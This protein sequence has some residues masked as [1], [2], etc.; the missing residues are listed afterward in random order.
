MPFTVS[1]GELNST[2]QTLSFDVTA[3]ADTA[4]ISG[5]ATGSVTEDSA[6]QVSGT[7]TVSDP[8]AGEAFFQSEDNIAGTYG[9]LTIDQH[10]EWSYTASND[11]SA[12]QSLADGESLT[13]IIEVQ[14]IDGT[15]QNIV[16]TINGTNDQT[17][18]EEAAYSYTIP[19][20]AFVDPDSDSLSVSATLANGDSLPAWLN[21][22][23]ASR[24]FSGTPDDA[25][26]GSL[27]VK[28]M[29]SD[30]SGETELFFG[31][32]IE[33][34]DDAPVANS[35]DLGDTNEDASIIITEASLLANASDVDGDSLSVTNLSLSADN[36][37]W[38]IDGGNP[39]NSDELGSIVNNN[40]GTWTFT[41]IANLNSGGMNHVVFDVTISDG[42]VG[43]E[44]TTTAQLGITPVNDG[45]VAVIDSADATADTGTS[46]TDNILFNDSDIE[47]DSLT[48]E[49]VNGQL[50]S[51]DTVIE[52]RF[53]DLTISADGSYTY[54]PEA[55]DLD[56]N[57]VGQWT[58]DEGNGLIAND[59]APNDVK[60]SNGTLES[61]ATFVDGGV[62]GGA[63]QLD[64]DLARVAIANSSE[65]NTYTGTKSQYTISMEF[66]ISPDNDLSGRQVLYEQGGASHGFN[67]YIDD[68]KLYAGAWTSGNSN[69]LDVDIGDIDSSQWHQV[70]FVLDADNSTME[71]WFNGESIGSDTGFPISSHAGAVAFGGI[72]QHTQFH[73][74][75]ANVDQGYGFNGLIDEARIYNRAL[76]HQEVNALKY[77]F[78]TG[79]L[80]DTFEYTVSDGTDT[81]TSSL[82][83]DVNRTPE[84]LSGTLSATED[85]GEIVGQLSA[86]D[87]DANE[88]LT[89]S[90]ENQ[91]SEGS[92][93]INSDGSYSF[94]PGSD[95]QNLA[96]DATR[97]VTFEYRVTDAQGD[98]SSATVTVTV[99]G[100]NDNPTA[101]DSTLTLSE[102][103][104]HTFAVADFGFADIDVG[105]NLHSVTIKQL[106]TNGSLQ[107]NGVDVTADQVINEVD[108]SNLTF[109]PAANA[110]GTGYANLIF[111]V[112][113]GELSSAEQTL[114]FDVAP[115]N[116]E[117]VVSLSDEL[118]TQIFDEDTSL[119]LQDADILTNISDIDTNDVLSISN[120]RVV[121]GSAV[122]VDNSDGTWTVT[123]SA[124]WVGS[125]RLL[126]DVSDGHATVT[127]QITYSVTNVGDP[128]IIGGEDTQIFG[129]DDY[130]FIDHKQLSITDA[131]GNEASFNAETINGTYGAL[132]I[133]TTGQWLYSLSRESADLQSM[134]NGDTLTDTVVVQ[135]VDGTTHDIVITIEGRNDQ[136]TV[137]TVDL[138]QINEDN[139]ITIT[140]EQLLA[141]ASDI[142]GDNL[143]VTNVELSDIGY[144]DLGGVVLRGDY[145]VD[146]Q[147]MVSAGSVGTIVDNGNGAWTFTPAAN[148]NGDNVNFNFTVSDGHN[149]EA[150][151]SATL[152]VTAVN[153][154]PVAVADTGSAT[155]GGDT[156][157]GANVILNDTD[158]ETFSFGLTVEDVNG[159]AVSGDTVIEGNFGDLTISE[160][161]QWTYDPA[162][163]DVTSNKIAHWRFDETSGSTAVDSAPDDS[164]TNNGTLTNGAAFVGG[165]VDGNAVAFGSSG[166]KVTLA[167]SAEINT[168]SGSK[169][170]YTINLEFQTDPANDLNGRQIL[171]EQGGDGNGY[172]VY[173]DDGVLYA[174][175][176]SSDNNWFG[177]W[178]STDLSSIDTTQWH[179]VS[180][181]LDA[182]NNRLEAWLDGVSM[183]SDTA[184]PM[185][186]HGNDAAFGGLNGTTLF[187][188]GASSSSANYD[189]SGRIDEASLFDRALTHQEINALKYEFETGTLQDTFEYTVSDGTDTS[190]S[191]L[192]IDVNRTPEALSGTLS[193]TEDGGE[194]V[195]QLSAIDLDANEVLTF[196][197]ENQPSE[198][199]VTINSD[200]S[201]SFSPGSDFQNLAKDATRDVTFEYRVTDAQGDSSSAT[202]TV[203]VTGTNDN[204]TAA[205]ST[206]TLSEDGFHTFAVADFGF[207]D[208]D[209]GD[210]LHSVTIKQLPT[211]GSLQLNGVDVTADQVINEVDISNLTFTPAA[212]ANGTGYANLIFT[213]SDGE[214]SSAE[215]TLS[216]D[217]APVNDE[218][219]VSLSDELDTQIFD[220]DT[221]LTLQD[222]DILTNISDIDTNDV[223]SISNA[224]VVSG[225]AVIVDNSDGTWTVTPSADWVGS[226]R[227]LF[228][229][230]DGHATVTTQITYSVT[231]VGD[232]AIIGGE[233]TQTFGEDDYDFIDHKQLSITDAD[234]NEASFNAETINGT[235]GALTIDTTGQW[236]YSLSRESADLQSM[237]NGDT[238][239]DTVVVQSVD[240]T[241]HDIVITIEG[242]NDQPTVRTVDLGQINE[243]NSITITQEQLLANASDIDGDN[244]TVTNVELSDIGYDDLGGV[245]LR[246]DYQ[247]DGQTMVSAGSVG[248]IVD[249]GNGAWTFTPAA[250][251]NGD[252]VNFNFTVS[253]GHNGE[254]VSSATLDVT[255]VNDG[256]V[257]VADTGSA[258]VGGDTLL[259]ANVIL[260]DTDVETFSF[261]LTVED[262]N[263][264]AVSG[265]TVIE[266]NFGDL[267]ISESGQWTYDPA[268]IDVTSNKIAHW[269]FDETSGFIAFDTAPDDNNADNGTVVNGGMFVEG[270][271]NGRAVE[272][273]GNND[274][275]ALEDSSEINQYTGNRYEY[276]I[277]LS[278]Q[279]GDDNDLS[280]RQMLFEDGGT[281]GY[282]IYIDNGTLYA[283][284]RS[285]GNNWD[286]AWLSTDISSVSSSEWHQVALVLDANNNRIEA[287]FDGESIGSDSASPMASHGDNVAIGN[288][289][290]K[291]FFHDGSYGT[292]G[293]H[294]FNGKM[295]E[296]SLYDRALTHQ[297]VNALKYEFETGT[298]QDTFNYTLSDGTDTSTS[299]LTIDVNRTPEAINGTLSATED[300]SE[301]V[302]Q[303]SAI[304]LDADEILTY[305]VV[306]QPSEGSVT[307]NSDGSYS[308]S[309]GNDFQNLAEGETRDVTF[310]YQVTDAQGDSSTATVTVTVSG[311]HDEVIFGS[312]SNDMIIA[313]HGSHAIIFSSD[314]I[315]TVN[316]I[317]NPIINVEVPIGATLSTGINN[318]DGTW[319]LTA[320]DLGSLSITGSENWSNSLRFDVSEL[321]TQPVVI[322][323]ASF[324]DQQVND[325]SWITRPI[326]DS[327]SYSGESGVENYT[328][329]QFN[330]EAA[331]GLNAAF[332]SSNGLITQTLSETFNVN[333]SYQLQID[334]GNRGDISF[335]DYEVRIKAGD[336]LLVSDGSLIPEDGEFETLTL[337]L[338]G[339]QYADQNVAGEPLIIEIASLSTDSGQVQ[340]DHMRMTV[341]NSEP[342][343]EE[344]I[345]IDQSDQIRGG[346]GNDILT[347][348]SDGDI[349]I[350][351]VDDIGT[352]EAPAEDVITDFHAGQNGDVIDLSDVLV[353]EANH[354]LDEYL[355][356]NFADG[357]TVVEVKSEAGGDV[358]QKIK[359]E[360]VDLS[361]LGTSDSEIINNLLDDGNLQ[362]D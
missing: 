223:L 60:I 247:V 64:G 228:D 356:F 236:L 326:G 149:G 331:E 35:V 182:D 46:F 39:V 224:R 295:D 285:S 325:G 237:Q 62:N 16:I 348:G 350:W 56:S 81:S 95:F 192:T 89:F 18:I 309:P 131:D 74:G 190:T 210:N 6:I 308:F 335:A 276:T 128:A 243:D 320:E 347:G 87:L 358:T 180:L 353:D 316:G 302:G 272:F 317:E 361:G 346:E 29:V 84:A 28:V 311:V 257:A 25:D 235:Y 150:V 218:P 198:G 82:T 151:S 165:G 267:T 107:L 211:N 329:S 121:S 50:I 222:A 32:N 26:L 36:G 271:V 157:L 300:G 241:T 275:V 307:I 187:H 345:N 147:T 92:V 352:A 252:N 115:V 61:G 189:F 120:A 108:I 152:D 106:P 334:V 255:A 250:N 199:S 33:A 21:F 94:S 80:Q 216:F 43:D 303:L 261:G 328:A 77:E 274:R 23:E 202:V 132:T 229:V 162:D 213:V 58:F 289:D 86:I 175:A 239:T 354:E 110:N 69:W 288:I 248:T 323:N 266:G 191:S 330:G 233:D 37:V 171:F 163:I 270:G 14:S 343:T 98:S 100:T 287:W 234:G 102:D 127:T 96:K 214:L 19:A 9:S 203:T 11:D 231:N 112:S 141:N 133:D 8:D 113:D 186:P 116:D 251:F 209:V 181:V 118:D 45:P 38:F 59:V 90:V 304:D 269:A 256:P 148:F 322:G 67:V 85:G 12:I 341:T 281:N 196:S 332:V 282:S 27:S 129:E 193:A 357:D 258:T 7:L 159:Q 240:G 156:L 54:T 205:D 73:D 78:E 71:A 123:P 259:G 278:F 117:P 172:N 212:N 273:D 161:G 140:Q 327:W 263:G 93:T 167:D 136:P 265:N 24:T 349:F 20:G 201:Y 70:S 177:N 99:T 145:Q 109:T 3:I 114:S 17:A 168:Y 169:N 230:S 184:S 42:T 314:F 48:V 232:P 249:N 126:F 125:G 119:T 297:E 293:S 291:A 88:V 188:D 268:D 31:L 277:N 146:G 200:G 111:T 290:G 351:H 355:H 197:V 57:L 41:P 310:E 242:R 339:T 296:V 318:G 170:Q 176:W 138:G 342:V 219:V 76:T 53:G 51:G 135:S 2:E 83:I 226:G 324:E 79:T 174:G 292:T 313:D 338:D 47:N 75:S 217:V 298:L 225:S 312:A 185:G 206:L 91:P 166:A 260:N 279:I 305:S 204:P 154:G 362:T 134:Q 359:L 183:G 221:S 284:A 301:I 306:S 15:K 336:T 160:N 215:Q 238:L 280:G 1:D 333:A 49:Q 144:D 321:S 244:L 262:V 13:D 246:G 207:A 124:D 10:G 337:N 101:A 164:A 5:D 299:T 254:A 360:G 4:V 44:V 294:G 155:V 97:D 130:D 245:V 34:V 340:F 179:Q 52:G 55:L 220:E 40:D 195:G 208:I 104:F 315:N 283:G 122:I 344:T 153:D 286:G 142:D 158:V 30:E 22:D 253:D 103:G 319:S 63:V 264:Q 68:G 105:D 65:I 139:S 227:L 178:I 143:T 173:I 66:Q 194:I 72:N 137:R